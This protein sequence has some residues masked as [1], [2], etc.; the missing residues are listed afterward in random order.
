MQKELIIG[1]KS[2]MAALALENWRSVISLVQ[3][4]HLPVAKIGG[5]WLTRRTLITRWI[6]ARLTGQIGVENGT[7]E[8]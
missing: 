8:G 4:D 6:D 3:K 7:A 5:R 1:K 2:I